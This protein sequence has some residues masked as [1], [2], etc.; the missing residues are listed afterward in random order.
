MLRYPFFICY[1]IGIFYF[2][3]NTKIAEKSKPKVNYSDVIKQNAQIV[4]QF[5]FLTKQILFQQN[6]QMSN[7]H[8]LI[9][10]FSWK[11]FS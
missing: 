10:L 4:S 8:F 9:K 11:I 1:A 2:P 3:Y 7:Q 6:A 5:F